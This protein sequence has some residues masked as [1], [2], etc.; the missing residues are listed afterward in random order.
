M[1]ILLILFTALFLYIVEGEFYRRLWSKDLEAYVNFSKKHAFCGE[2]G[3]LDI[4]L[5]N[6]KLLPLPWLWVKLHVHAS[7][8]FEGAEN[9]KNES[10]YYNALF[11][12]MGWQKITRHLP[13]ECTRRGYFPIKAFDVVG[14]SVLFNGKHSKSYEG[15][16]LTV[17]PMPADISDL[18][19]ILEKTEGMA[20][21]TG[22]IN[23]DPF[24]FAGVRE[25][26]PYDS[27]KEINFKATAHTG[28][29][30]SNKHDPTVK[31]EIAIIL[32][33]KLLKQNFEEERF[34]YSIS[35]A[36]SLAEYYISRGFTV[37]LYSNGVDGMDKNTVKIEFGSG[38]GTLT[39]IY[40]ALA[41]VEYTSAEAP[42]ILMP[43]GKN[44]A[45]CIFIS[46]TVDFPINELYKKVKE[47]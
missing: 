3:S 12:I 47:S 41:R 22:F 34:E 1:E 11:C 4:E 21:S 45:L 28:T 30:M 20:E 7:L 10:M 42:D 16:S 23:P 25:Y 39:D 5:V 26:M 18:W 40:E 43:D 29:L 13:F 32:C 2:K 46:P 27:L 37:A 31:G 8:K 44:D 36:A 17:Y 24:E 33:M 6:R 15:C 19:D 35:L 14:T 9:N 38:E